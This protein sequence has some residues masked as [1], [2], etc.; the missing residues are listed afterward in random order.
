MSNFS[1]AVFSLGS[2]SSKKVSRVFRRP[3]G[4]I[5]RLADE[6]T[7][8]FPSTRDYEANHLSMV[9]KHLILVDVALLRSAHVDM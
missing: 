3:C 9:A 5:V 4:A 7:E 8:F 2:R 1:A 6:A